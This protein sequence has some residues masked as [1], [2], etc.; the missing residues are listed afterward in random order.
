MS[1]KKLLVITYHFPPSAAA[2]GFRVLGFSRYL[3]KFGWQVA[4]VAPPSM[5]WEA[6]DE[7][8]LRQ[9]PEGTVVRY[10]PFTKSK[11][12][13]YIAF[14]DSWLFKA[15]FACLK[16]VRADRPSA[17]LTTSP[18]HHV[19]LLGLLLSKLSG[20][21]WVAD[22]RDPW[23]WTAHFADPVVSSKMKKRWLET[24]LERMVIRYA[25]KVVVN[26]PQARETMVRFY[27]EYQ[28]K[29][30]VVTNGFEPG[31]F[32][33]IRQAPADNSPVRI[34]YT[35]QIYA[36]RNPKH[37]FAA[38]ASIINARG[39]GARPIKADFFGAFRLGDSKLDL[40][41]EITSRGLEGIVNLNREIGYVES[42]NEVS[43]SDILLL[44]DTPGRKIG[45][46]SKLYEYIGSGSGILA[47]I[48]PDSDSAWA[49]QESGAVYRIAKPDDAGLIGQALS[50]LI[51]HA[52]QPH[53]RDR[54]GGQSSQF[55][56]ENI[57]RLLAAVLESAVNKQ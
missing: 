6:N 21:P 30:S 41:H 37:F 44:L 28:A 3:P 17:I 22:F 39:P 24:R 40:E 25:D 7:S 16:S 18:P 14:T 50:E 8:L 2:G 43:N 1:K 12:V 33:G 49:L 52:Q 23:V 20:I 57:T 53:Q 55:T 35:G 4:V 11:L 15:F 26:A 31:L 19:H 13:R 38:L 27:P 56:R 5:P 29:V 32:A 10:V 45:V 51:D 54:D 42:L 47:L 36:G 9:V 48:E 34:I 46:P